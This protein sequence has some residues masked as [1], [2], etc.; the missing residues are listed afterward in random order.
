MKLE[1]HI[2]T[3]P[4]FPKEGIMFKDITT[5]LK[6]KDAF[7]FAI[8]EFTE[9]YRDSGITKVVGAESRGFI[10]G[11]VL[12]HELNCGFVPAR[13]KGKLPAKSISEEYELEYG[14]DSLH[15]HEDAIEKGDKVLVVDD[16]IATGG[17]VK[18]VCDMV[19]KLGGTVVECSFL[20]ELTFL[21]GREK[22]GNIPAFSLITY[23]SEE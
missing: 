3:V 16:L 9:R 6:H 4:H 15:M 19:K 2:R 23:D 8:K 12:A 14:T 21:K 1:K 11:A 10:F 22:L 17:T 7:R 5:L 20:I 13:K 18:A